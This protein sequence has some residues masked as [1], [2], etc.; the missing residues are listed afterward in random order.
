MVH[1][2][3]GTID[4]CKTT[5]LV[6]LFGERNEGDGFAMIKRML[7]RLVRGYDA[8][9]LSSGE[10]W[11]LVCREGYEPDD[12]D[13]ACSIGPYLFSAPVLAAI[14]AKLRTMIAAG[15]SPLWLDEIGELELN[16]RGFD[17]VMQEMVAAGVELYVV[18]RDDLVARVLAKYG[19]TDYETIDSI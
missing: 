14:E 18:V 19:I 11:P 10:E 12:F 3:T 2:I 1:V 4:A 8:R 7:G 9:Q 5:K 6:T 15:I 17:A 16:G 13:V